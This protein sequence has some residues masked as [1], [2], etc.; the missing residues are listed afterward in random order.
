MASTQCTGNRN[1]FSCRLLGGMWANPTTSLPQQS[2]PMGREISTKSPFA[3]SQILKPMESLSIDDSMGYHSFKNQSDY[4]SD[5]HTDHY[6]KSKTNHEEDYNSYHRHK[7]PVSTWCEEDPTN[8]SKYTC[9]SILPSRL[10]ISYHL[11]NCNSI[12]MYYLQY[13]IC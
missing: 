13:Y 11:R 3:E 1:S 7:D 10:A 5:Y 2:M 12:L 8:Y 9:Y 6:V 4:H